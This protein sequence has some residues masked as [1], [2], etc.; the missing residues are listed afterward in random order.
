MILSIPPKI[1]RPEN[2]A[3]WM[4]KHQPMGASLQLM[5]MLQLADKNT[6][7]YHNCIPNIQRVN[8]INQ[9]P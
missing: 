6:V 9:N 1:I 2:T 4:E 3:Y 7:S 5:Q 8:Y